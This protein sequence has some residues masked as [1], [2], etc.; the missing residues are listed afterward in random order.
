MCQARPSASVHS[1]ERMISSQA[2]SEKRGKKQVERKENRKEKQ[3]R[4]RRES[5]SS[6]HHASS[7]EH[8]DAKDVAPPIKRSELSIT[9]LNFSKNFEAE[10]IDKYAQWADDAENDVLKALGKEGKAA[11]AKVVKNLW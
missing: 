1:S 4:R 7:D 6:E 10:N 11:W 3:Q 5:S 2:E 9:A 8:A